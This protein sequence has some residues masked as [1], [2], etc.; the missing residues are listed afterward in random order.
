MPMPAAENTR[1]SSGPNSPAMTASTPRP[2][3]SRANRSAAAPPGHAV[4][5]VHDDPHGGDLPVLRIDQGKRGR[6][7]KDRRYGI[8][9]SPGS[10]A[11][12]C[13]PHLPI[14]GLTL[15]TSRYITGQEEQRSTHQNRAAPAAILLVTTWGW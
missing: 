12:N 3:R 7:P 1:V 9:K 13:Y 15:S 4:R 2:A 11:G 14:A 8:V 5:W 10:H 6:R